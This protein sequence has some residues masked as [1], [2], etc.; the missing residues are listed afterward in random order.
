MFNYKISYTEM[1]TAVKNKLLV[2]VNVGGVCVHV[3]ARFFWGGGI[4]DNHEF[5]GVW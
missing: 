5:T 3:R 1:L 4:Q 2:L